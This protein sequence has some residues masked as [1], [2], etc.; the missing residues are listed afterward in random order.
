MLKEV[1]LTLTSYRFVACLCFIFSGAASVSYQII[2][3]RQAMTY[4]GVITPVISSVLSTF[5]LGLAIGTLL[6]GKVTH[7]L[8]PKG[9]LGWYAAAEL[10]IGAGALCVPALF[11]L[12]YG[13]I[14][15][16]G[17]LNS[18]LYLFL[19]WVIIALVLLPVCTLIGLTLPLI[20]R[21]LEAGSKDNKNFGYLYFSN[22]VGALIGCIFPLLL[23][24]ITGFKATLSF[25]TFLNGAAAILALILYLRMPLSA[26]VKS[27]LAL[28]S[29][30]IKIR[31]EEIPAGYS[32]LLFLTGMVAMGSEVIWIKSFTPVLTT[33]VY[34]FS[35]VLAVYLI[36]N[37]LG[38]WYYL[39]QSAQRNLFQK[40]L[41]LLPAAVLFPA[42]GSSLMFMSHW[43]IVS[44]AVLCLLLGCL[45]PY[46]VDSVCGNNPGKTARAY[47]WNFAG[48]IVG[49]LTAT[50]VFFPWIGLKGSLIAY[51]AILLLAIQYFLAK[52]PKY[53]LI[54]LGVF[55]VTLITVFTLP[56]M[57]DAI[58]RV[59][60]LHRDHVGYIGSV[61]HGMKKRLLVNGIGMTYLTTITKNMAYLPLAYRPQAKSALVICFGMGTTLRSLTRWPLEKITAVELSPGVVASFGYFHD[62]APRVLSDPRVHV[63]IDDGRRYLSR[64]DERYDLITID[65]PPPVSA[66]ASGLLYSS[67]FI[68]LAK[69]RLT[70]NGILVHWLPTGD[71]LLAHAVVN[72]I[73]LHFKNIIAYR[74]IEGWGIHILAS[75]GPLPDMSAQE[76]VQRLSEK[77]I[78]DLKEYSPDLTIETIADRSLHRIDLSALPLPGMANIYMSDD[79]LWNEFFLWRKWY[80]SFL[81]SQAAQ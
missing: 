63:V 8:H 2:W 23:I 50:Y 57:E 1:R 36:S 26:G 17:E 13:L 30:G 37:F 77:A 15:Q 22:L 3:L 20:M 59:G 48:C 43:S 16:E 64:T 10:L 25:T 12:G 41:V 61:G 55:M 81:S 45:T 21:F 54:S 27:A 71:P 60:V 74:S 69:S 58:K 78:D 46:V 38:T 4:F 62:D 70:D 80:G 33:T 34:A 29:A 65:P 18:G 56:D 35:A 75:D 31:R 19:S 68:A 52:R 32:A 53:F 40:I 66:S 73:R 14:L 39:K 44:I 7:Y 5:M 42:L 49:P 28:S 79:R 11:S 6:A 9:A 76:F 72:A 47:S 24:E 51:A 67:E